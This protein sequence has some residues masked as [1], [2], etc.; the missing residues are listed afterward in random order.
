MSQCAG[1]LERRGDV[2]EVLHIWSGEDGDAE[3]RGFER[4]LSAAGRGEAGADEGDARDGVDAGKLADGVE[5]EDGG[6]RDRC[7]GVDPPRPAE[8]WVGQKRGN[9]VEAL[10]MARRQDGDEL[11]Q[12]RQCSSVGA[13]DDGFFTFAGAAADEHWS[14]N[15]QVTSEERDDG[16]LRGGRWWQ[17][18]FEIAGDVDAV[19]RRTDLAQAFGIKRGLGEED[20]RAG[21][22][23]LPDATES[24]VARIGAVRD[25]RIDDSD[26]DALFGGDGEIVGP[27]L[28]FD[29]HEQARAERA[30][31]AA[32]DPAEVER[33]IKDGSSA[34]ALACELLAGAGGG[35][36]DDTELGVSAGERFA[37]AQD[38]RG[39]SEDF[40]DGNGVEPDGAG[41]VWRGER[42]FQAGGNE[43]EAL[44]EAFAI[45][46]G[47]EHDG[48]P[49]RQSNDQDE[50]ECG[51]IEDGH[52]LRGGTAP[53]IMA[54]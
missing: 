5:Q 21:E 17:V 48:E 2:A 54:K 3:A 14:A 23:F 22:Q 29:E 51:A 37:Q 33:E 41:D 12:L 32:Q 47:D 6:G 18:I 35:G 34:E 53:M 45:F 26:G 4:I 36:D 46:A 13:E 50:S 43:A 28:R 25:A 1:L 15:W 10:G 11:R 40:S 19:R 42:L 44:A 8:C 7:G 16:Q 24:E 30:E 20:A 27:E 39:G 9:G 49:V 38:E 52:T 31:I